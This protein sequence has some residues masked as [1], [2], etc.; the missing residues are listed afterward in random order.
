MTIVTGVNQ[1]ESATLYFLMP[2]GFNG[3]FQTNT[4][5]GRYG[6][7]CGLLNQKKQVF[8]R[9]VVK[10]WLDAWQTVFNNMW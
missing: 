4:K 7:P 2:T 3:I 8:D 1:Y 6:T 5:N 9:E 10:W